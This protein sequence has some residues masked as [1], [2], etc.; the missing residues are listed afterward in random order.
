MRT[1][2]RIKGTPFEELRMADF[3]RTDDQLID[4]MKARRIL[5]SLQL[6]WSLLGRDCIDFDGYRFF[7]ER[8]WLSSRTIAA[9]FRP[10][11]DKETANLANPIKIG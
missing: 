10:S 8:L 1:L 2:I 6:W 4:P 11:P 3:K 5:I 9:Y 7:W